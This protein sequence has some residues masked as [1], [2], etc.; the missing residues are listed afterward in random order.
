MEEVQEIDLNI[1]NHNNTLRFFIYQHT[2]FVWLN[3]QGVFVNV[4]SLN[5][6]MTINLLME[7][8]SGI[9]KRQQNEL[10]VFVSENS[11]NIIESG[12][13]W[14]K[15]TIINKANYVNSRPDARHSWA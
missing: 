6:K 5:E 14:W 7:N 9:N 1:A 8:M 13:A 15:S 11:S 12:V 2:R 4:Q 3:D 10:W